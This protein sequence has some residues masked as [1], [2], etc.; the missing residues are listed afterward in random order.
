MAAPKPSAVRRPQHPAA[1]ALTRAR[2]SP[3]RSRRPTHRL[4]SQTSPGRGI[5]RPS[6]SVRAARRSTAPTHVTTSA[7][8]R[9]LPSRSSR[10]RSR[11]RS[12]RDET[13]ARDRLLEWL[14]AK[15]HH[16]ARPG[17]RRSR[18]RQD[19]PPRRLHA[20]DPA[21]H[22]LVSA[23]RDD[24]RLDRRSC[25]HLVAA[26]REHDPAFG[27]AT[28]VPARRARHRRHDRRR[29]SSRRS[30]ASCT[31]SESKARSSSSTT[32]T[33]SRHARAPADR[34]RDRLARPRTADG[35]VPQPAR[36]G[37]ADRPP[38]SAGRGGRDRHG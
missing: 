8:R 26:V 21:A 10:P 31:R 29:R 19:D 22:A 3:Y 33:S 9:E 25:S 20:S 36:P 6:R 14:D 37:P 34:P 23:G 18:L 4:P 7:Q 28:C 17:H 11:P 12:L 24:A 30:S 27:S 13:L 38:A 5:A 15:I 2:R 32:T 1:G 16:R 35:R